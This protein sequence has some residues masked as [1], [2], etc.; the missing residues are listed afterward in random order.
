MPIFSNTAKNQMLDSLD[1]TT[2]APSAG[3]GFLSLHTAYSATGTNEATGG[4]PA[5]AR[6]AAV[7]SAAASGQKAL[8][9]AVTFDVPA[10]TY[11]WIG[12]WSAITVGTFFGMMP[13]NAGVPIEFETDDTTADTLKS[14]AHGLANGDQVVAWPTLGKSLPTDAGS[15]LA[16]G[17]IYFVVTSTTDS[18]QLSTTS[19]GAAI[20]FTGKGSGMVQKILPEVFAAQGTLQVSSA[21]LDLTGL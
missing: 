21:T 19:G 18:F 12:L 6:K 11:P 10:G 14:V 7:W 16:V 5:Y 3:I 20:N 13:A 1:E 8:T 17:T 2:A 4:S 15:N 9:S